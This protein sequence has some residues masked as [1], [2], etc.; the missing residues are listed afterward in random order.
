MRNTSKVVDNKGTAVD[1][2][3]SLVTKS[4]Q[5]LDEGKNKALFFR[6]SSFQSRQQ[7]QTVEELR[8]RKAIYGKLRWASVPSQPTLT[9]NGRIAYAVDHNILSVN[10][11]FLKGKLHTFGDN[12]SA[13]V[14][15]EVPVK[16]L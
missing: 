10:F 5:Q 1:N 14:S 2:L 11:V 9:A 15:L 6:V 7:Q 8:I 4:G 13:I 12:E 16:Y 3:T